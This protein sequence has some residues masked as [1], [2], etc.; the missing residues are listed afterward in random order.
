MLKGAF[1]VNVE[2]VWL[3]VKPYFVNPDHGLV[4]IVA[5]IA[6]VTALGIVE[7]VL[8]GTFRFREL[9]RFLDTKILRLVAGLFFLVL[10]SPLSQIVQGV[11]VAGASAT[12]IKLLA[13]LKDRAAGILV[14]V[15]KL[16]GRDVNPPT[17]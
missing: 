1:A 11:Y 17:N 8:S 5:G 2:S 7:A 10:L 15:G 13:D 3:T 14:A 16:L 6:L 4:A 12:A 9:P